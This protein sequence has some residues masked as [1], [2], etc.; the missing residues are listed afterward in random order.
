MKKDLN[1]MKFNKFMYACHHIELMSNPL[2]WDLDTVFKLEF[3][4]VL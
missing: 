3:V 1:F 4:G 2:T